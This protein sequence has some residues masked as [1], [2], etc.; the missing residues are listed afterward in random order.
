M[1]DPRRRP[2]TTTAE[3]FGRMLVVVPYLVRH[4][5]SRLD[6]V[7]ALF[8]IP[9]EAL[10]R[11]L[12]LLFMSGLPPYGPGD[13]IEVEVDEDGRVWIAMADHFS[14]PL[15]LTRAEA[16]AL[17]VRGTELAATPGIPEAP[18]LESAL[19]TLSRS[20]GSDAID[21]EGRIE[22]IPGASPPHLE[23]VRAAAG[24][25]RSLS[26]SYRS[27]S[28][29]ATGARMIDP[30]QVFSSLGHWYVAAWDADAD[31]E[32]LF[33]ID[34]MLEV[35][36]TGDSFSPRGLEGAGRALYTPAE[37]D[38]EV[39]LRLRRDARWVAEYYVTTEVVELDDGA[40]E[41]SMPV[42]N[43][44]WLVRL[45]LRLGHDVEVIS[46]PELAA[47]TRQMAERTL[48]RYRDDQP[49]LARSG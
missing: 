1:V 14:R 10:R 12:D 11:D 23:A 17:Y 5:G 44:D 6:E 35:E 21:A 46:P 26:I 13:L 42:G 32:R 43:L 39:R 15:R 7:A 4:P 2:A 8:S 3:R 9:A 41:I 24:T 37:H 40:L 28:S 29:G 33:R 27:V 38:V 16:L 22:A 25:H 18:S 34:R 45:L 48:A 49:D 20:L 30:E 31:A 47:R 19:G 36:P